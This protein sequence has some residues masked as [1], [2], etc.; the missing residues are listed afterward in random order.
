[1]AITT[2]DPANV[3]AALDADLP[4]PLL[5][6]ETVVSGYLRPE[7]VEQV[8]QAFIVGARAHDGQVRRSG[9]PYIFH[10]VAVAR[11]LADMA[12]D[13]QTIIA[14][15]LHDTIE[16]TEL[17]HEAVA[18]EFG[19]VVGDIVEGVTKLDK[20]QFSNQQ[21]AAAESF[22]KM[23]LAMARD[24]RVIL[25]KLADR[26]HNMR[27]IGFMR[28]D[29]QKR[30][31]RETLDIYAA[32][33]QR[34]GI[35]AFKRELQELSF[36]ALHPMRYR[37]IKSHASAA[38]G[39]NEERFSTIEAALRT[40]LDA[41]RIDCSIEGRVKS[42]YSIYDKMKRKGA[43]VR[44][45]LD[46][47][48]FR[49]VVDTVQECYLALGVVHNLYKPRT[50]RFK[51]Y[52]AI[53]KNNGYQ[54]LHTVLV[55][56]FGDSIEIQIRTREMDTVAERGIAAHWVYKLAE[57]RDS[58]RAGA[59]AREWLFGVLDMQQKAGS[60]MDF[61]EHV[62]VDLFPDEVYVFTPDGEIRSMPKHA[63]VLDFAYAVHT[64]VGN[65]AVRAWIDK[66]RLVP[67]RY[68]PKSGETIKVITSQSS[69][70]RPNWLEFVVTA[71]ARTAI[72]HYLKNLGHEEAVRI[73]HLMLDGALADLGT[74]L[75]TI[76]ESRV[77]EYLE[78]I[79][80]KRLEELL[81]DVALG[82]RM[83]R[84]VAQQL[85]EGSGGD[86]PDTLPVSR[87]S[88]LLTGEEDH[89][90]TYGVCCHPVAGDAITGYLSAGKGLVVHRKVCR[91]LKE[92]RKHPER[93]IDVAW[94]SGRSGTLF[95]V[96]LK[97]DVHNRPGVLAK[98]ASTIS[99]MDTNIENVQN[100]ERDGETSELYFVINVR[101]RK[102]LARVIRRLRR[103][104]DVIAVH[105]D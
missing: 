17:T 61:L 60:S 91:N 43:G 21:E 92:L 105:R 49:I 50:S 93:L 3:P 88:L 71:R 34:L 26:L 96:P 82:N 7:E 75:D 11:I 16:D 27:T 99:G 28:P 77:D 13:S 23:I 4:P 55:G 76:G 63:T 52:I 46:L 39:R 8:H 69:N 22:R 104:K 5:E 79:K 65:R 15:L 97:V 86:H 98:V 41:A 58:G 51:D 94:Q 103:T 30:I 102:H 19:S 62:K 64:D 73:G 68:R 35:D 45:V 42:P 36:S 12:M 66:T 40:R 101:D 25:I 47:I 24:I 84:V 95:P 18:E 89:V 53:P 9:E 6:L 32:I 67:L 72:R 100:R 87:E 2:L 59:R 48:G 80:L 44:D 37:V 78:G 70:P 83:P 74:S 90:V 56:P 20:M 57:N 1:M 54:S 38:M 14:A 33:A 29:K 10:P 81:A 31:A 85:L